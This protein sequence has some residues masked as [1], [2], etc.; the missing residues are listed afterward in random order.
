MRRLPL[1]PFALLAASPLA[2]QQ[3]PDT[4]KASTLP[5]VTVS[6]TRSTKPLLLAPL[7]VSSVG[8]E[9]LRATAGI[10]LA[11]ALQGIPGVLAQS[12]SSGVDTRITIRG[13]GA[14]GAGDR[15]NAGTMRGIRVM[16]DGMPE[17]EPDGRTSL[18]LIDLATMTGVDVIRSNSSALWGNAAGGVIS[19]NSTPLPGTQFDFRTMA[20]SFGLRR[21]IAQTSTGTGES[22]V[23]ASVSRT[24]SDGWRQN[25]A[26]DRSVLSSG[27]V[28]PLGTRT[29]IALRLNASQNNF[30]IPGPLTAA[31][32]LAT[33]RLANATYNTRR[34]RR[35]NQIIRFGTTLDREIG[36]SGVLTIM[37]YVT[38]KKLIRSE[39]GT[40]REFNRT[41]GGGTI[42][43]HEN[44]GV[45]SLIVGSDV[46]H[47]DGPARF[48]SLSA[49][50]EKG[51]TLQQ[52]KNESATTAGLFVQDE[53]TV[54]PK[55]SLNLGARF[56]ALRYG[57]T[58]RVTPKLSATRNYTQLS[59][60]LGAVYRPSGAN[61]FYAN[62]GAGVETPAG[63]ETDPAGTFGQ[64]TVTGISPLLKPIRSLTYEIGTRNTLAL[65]A[66][67][68]K[69]LRYEVSLF[70]TEVRD[71]LVPYRGGRFYFNAGKTRR[72]G[73]EL[74]GELELEE[75][76]AVRSTATLMRAKY[77]E[78]V[79]DSVHYGKP[80]AFA[81]YAGNAAVGV[82][83]A[84]GS[85]GA[86]WDAPSMP[87]RFDADMQYTGAY[88]LN[89][90]NTVE[91]PS[92]TVFNATISL[93]QA[94]RLFSSVGVTGFV[95]VENLL[96]RRYMTS[97]FLNPDVVAG[98]FV[99]Y[100]PGFP[101]AF[102]VSLGLVRM[103]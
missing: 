5:K 37:S 75:G 73:V 22:R 100:E 97:G 13:F 35:E 12:R 99:A 53:W 46:Q 4:T 77:L 6:A 26:S 38:P 25:S 41:H 24:E 72:Q 7:A 61:L 51:T 18:D 82:P 28:S 55:V 58:D 60:K 19:L 36:Q 40:Y 33:P 11:D 94:K 87:L 62:L 8:I 49:A 44:L 52:D 10:G 27:L 69:A 15:S 50:G 56:D 85:V 102:I 79:V 93:R 80:G 9:R 45:H 2:G 48:W 83:R 17:T 103:P 90:A 23:Y 59:P 95:R 54:S 1:L 30:G 84:M 68:A 43:L 3:R 101:R 16:I 88:M 76:F 32:A 63:N 78:Y 92:A 65:T 70:N 98:Q 81:N 14:R 39:R 96:D 47:Q 91:L 34:E 66:P 29:R 31:Q 89:D 21:A 42:S 64:D 74:G 57:L 86:R 20:G 71:E 67:G